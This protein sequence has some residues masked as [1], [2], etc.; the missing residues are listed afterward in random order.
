[1]L[2]YECGTRIRTRQIGIRAHPAL[3]TEGRSMPKLRKV[4]G[5]IRMAVG[6]CRRWLE[7]QKARNIA[8]RSDGTVFVFAA[9]T[10]LISAISA[11]SLKELFPQ[12]EKLINFMLI[13]P[14][15]IWVAT[16]L[17]T[18]ALLAWSGIGFCFG[19]L[20]AFYSKEFIRR[21]ESRPDTSSR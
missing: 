18:A 3:S 20:C 2:E 8:S 13:M 16:L 9:G 21:L 17:V 15:K 19:L 7:A 11:L 14:F 10:G 6:E 4:F 5:R 12:Y 1:M